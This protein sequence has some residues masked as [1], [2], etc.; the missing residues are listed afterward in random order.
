MAWGLSP[1]IIEKV[2][3]NDFSAAHYLTICKQAFENLNWHISYIGND[4]IIAY[5][6]ISW[7]SYAEEV[8][9]KIVKNTAILK[10]ECVGYQLLFYDY[11][12][13]R[14]NLDLFF[15][16]AEYAAFHLKDKYPEA[17]ENYAL[18]IE[19]EPDFTIQNPPMAGKEG[20]SHL[21]TMFVFTQK[22]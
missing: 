14:K 19:A 18:Q 11:G 4:G 6:N 12:K 13:N 2:P 9:V 15:N 5:T 7:A 17:L 1:R 10:S 21:G 3:L 22:F 8:S 16:E 20:L